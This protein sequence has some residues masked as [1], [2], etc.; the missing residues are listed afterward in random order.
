MADKP[1]PQVTAA[2]LD[3]IN[4]ILRRGHS[5]EIR[6]RKDSVVI[7]EVKAQVTKEIKEISPNAGK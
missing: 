1:I 4:A 7:L 2:E 6:K 5:A 3:E